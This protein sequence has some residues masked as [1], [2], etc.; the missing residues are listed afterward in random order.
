MQLQKD[1]RAHPG[2]L[3]VKFQLAKDTME[4]MLRSMYSMRDHLSDPVR[5][6]L[7]AFLFPFVA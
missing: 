2:E 7:E 6:M 5:A 4:T 3:E 1:D